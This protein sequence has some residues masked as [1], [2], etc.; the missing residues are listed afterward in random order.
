[1]V[2]DVAAV[3]RVPGQVF[4]EVAEDFDRVRLRYPDDLVDDVLSYSGRAGTRRRALEVGAGTGK[5]TLAFAARS[6]P[7][8]ALEPDEAMA[9]VLAHRIARVGEVRVVRCRFEDYVPDEAF[10]LLYAADA[11]HWTEPDLRWL[12]A[13]QALVPGG[14]LALFWNRDRIDDSSLRNAMVGVLAEIAPA[15]V[16]RDSPPEPDRLLNEGP[17][18]ELAQRTEFGDVIGRIYPS[19]LIIP[20]VDYLTYMSTRSQ[21]RMQTEPTRKRLFAA[22]ADVFSRDVPVAVHSV[23]YL[24][25]R[26]STS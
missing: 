24:A 18:S 3:D 17:G 15:V 21:I 5:A 6:V 7:I 25:R 22:M 2:M 8:V 12:R 10:G 19:R 14:T 16:I 23:L 20:G 9:A 1:M 13:E 26:K 11:W 4:G